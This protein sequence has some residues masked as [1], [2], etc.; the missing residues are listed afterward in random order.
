MDKQI[1]LSD[2]ARA[3][4]GSHDGIHEVAPD[5]GYQRLMLVNVVFYGRPG[6]GDRA[7]TLVDAG[8]PGTA[9]LLRSAAEDR[10]GKDA[11]PAAI[12]MTHGHFDHVGALERLADEW[13]APIYAHRLELPY[14]DGTSSYPPPDPSVG[15]LM[16]TLSP[17]FPRGPI[18]VRERL[19]ALPDDG[20]VP[21]MPGWRWVATPGH[22]EGHV[23]FFRDA[24]RAL[25]SGDAVITTRQESAYAVAVQSPEMHGPPAY[26][27]PDWHAAGLSAQRLAALEPE[28]IVPGHGRAFE[29]TPM[30]TALHQLAD[31]FQEV[32]VPKHGRYVN[33][34]PDA[35]A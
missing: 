15:G 18:N 11:R 21:G 1:P 3:D 4:E 7:W 14:L 10:F 16:A 12:V 26:F 25:I 9:P 8:L 13:D 20:S 24:D 28:L 32:A 30:R 31:R 2:S 33:E 5:L 34:S 17:L 29:G 22:T 19:L 6:A 27:T 35:R 23:S